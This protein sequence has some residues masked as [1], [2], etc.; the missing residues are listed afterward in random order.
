FLAEASVGAWHCLVSKL[1]DALTHIR[2]SA[3]FIC[4]LG[5]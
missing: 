3:Y 2:T 4:A 1:N 5:L